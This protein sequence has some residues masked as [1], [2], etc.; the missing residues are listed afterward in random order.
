MK[1]V[2][3]FFSLFVCCFIA[4]SVSAQDYNNYD[5]NQ[6][7]YA[8]D[9]NGDGN[10]DCAPPE[11]PMNDCYCLY[12]KYCPQYY[13][14]W[15]CEYVPQYSYKKC[16]RYVPQYYEKSCC[17]MVP[18]YYNVTCCRQVPQYYTTCDCKYVPKY[19][20]QK[21]CRWVPQYYYK[22]VC[23]PTCGNNCVD[24]GCNTGCAR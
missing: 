20:C 12:C 6:S 13:D 15:N 21:C 9:Y 16:C 14:K 17:R 22:H 10:C 2:C 3:L 11:R 7:S 19:S 8:G 18:Q 5:Y 24:A 4:A 23:E 1:K